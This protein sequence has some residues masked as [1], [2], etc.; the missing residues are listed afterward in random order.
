[1]NE[2]ADKTVWNKTSI[3]W[4]SLLKYM[5]RSY[6]FSPPTTDLLLVSE[7]L[8]FSRLLQRVDNKV[9]HLLEHRVHI[10]I[11]V[12]SGHDGGVVAP[13]LLPMCYK[14]GMARPDFALLILRMLR[15]VVAVLY[16]LRRC[17]RPLPGH[18]VRSS[19]NQAGGRA[20][21]R[22]IQ[23]DHTVRGQLALIQLLRLSLCPWIAVQNPAERHAVRLA[24]SLL[25]Y[26]QHEH[27]GDCKKQ[28]Q[29]QQQ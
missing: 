17:V 14:S 6:F 15:P 3:H 18:R 28:Q 11:S 8:R 4:Q 23:D 9:F 22:N 25:Q 24:E 7:R 16:R 27:I 19:S 12:D 21:L 1:M 26:L 10:H 29:Q 5:S 2:Y 13:E 20:C